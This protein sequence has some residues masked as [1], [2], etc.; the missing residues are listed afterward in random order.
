MAVVLDQL[1]PAER[2]TFVLHDVFGVSFDRIA[3]LVGRTP[4][5]CRQL[6]SRA[7]HSVRASEPAPPHASPDPVLQAVVDSFIAACAG[8]D[9]DALAR[10]LHPD[11]SG[12]ATVD[13]RRVGFASG[14]E[15]VAERIMFFLGPRSGWLLS[16]LPL[17][18]GV[19]VVAT[20]DGEPVAILRL[21]VSDGCIRSMHSVL[22]PA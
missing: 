16:P 15:T 10:T 2:A 9:R 19:A 11:V 7:R 8:G 14:T 22:L 12:W 3:E 18:E 17:D 1:S 21:D 13:G 20:R 4:S 5:A 6:A